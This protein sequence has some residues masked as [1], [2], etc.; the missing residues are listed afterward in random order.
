MR[1]ALLEDSKDRIDTLIGWFPNAEVY[2]TDDVDA[3]L[4]QVQSHTYDLLIL[5]H[6]LGREQTGMHAVQRLEAPGPPVLVWTN[7]PQNGA[8]MVQIL[9]NGSFLSA[10]GF[11][12]TYV[13]FHE[14]TPWI[15]SCLLEK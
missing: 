9:C 4:E 15:V 8:K 14:V 12:A 3:F 1:I 5:D 7:E 10:G 13:P 2:A 6:S 11:R